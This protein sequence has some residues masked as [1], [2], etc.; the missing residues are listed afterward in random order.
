MAEL[1][2]AKC[3]RFTETTDIKQRTTKNNRQMF[4]GICVV[5]ETKNSKSI[6]S[7]EAK[8][9]LNNVINNLP[10][11]MHLPG[12]SFT[13]PGTKLDKRLNPDLT[14]KAWT[15]PINRV[16][17]AAYHHDICYVKAKDLKRKMRNVTEMLEELDGIY[18]PTLRERME[19]GVVS[20]I[21]MTKNRFGMGLKKDKIWTD[22][23]DDELNKP[24]VMKFRN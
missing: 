4:Q 14:P 20:K 3:R 22:Q 5:C 10:F 21:I 7:Q 23:L 15:K 2:C 6:K 11:Q 13:G 24:V 12:H 18:N 8:G 17:K 1:H 16:V 19:R 9:F